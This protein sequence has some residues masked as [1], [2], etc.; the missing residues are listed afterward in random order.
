LD[1]VKRLS[2]DPKVPLLLGPW[3]S[4][5]TLMIA[6]LVND[7]G[8]PVITPV[9]SDPRVLPSGENVFCVADTDINKSRVLAE[10]LFED[11]HRK[12]AV[13]SDRGRYVSRTVAG[14]FSERFEELGGEVILQEDYSGGDFDFTDH[15]QEARERGAD[16]L[17]FSE[18]RMEP[19]VSLCRTLKSMDWDV[20]LATQVA[21]FGGELLRRGEGAVEGLYLSTTYVPEYANPEQRSFQESFRSMFDG[22]EATHREAQVYDSLRLAVEALDAVGPDREKLREYL[23]SI[24]RDSEPYHGV[25]GDFS[26][27]R[28]LNARP[29]YVVR[30]V[31][32][33]YQIVTPK[34]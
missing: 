29:A 32:G 9:S 14:L 12:A 31:K 27:S 34:S 23:T 15:A 1:I 5:Q 3:T 30:V 20:P 17:F 10:H 19:V 28:H 21:S 25:S 4:Q 8:L 11:G 33:A 13:F 6:P 24:G 16:C 22:R 18:Y 2:S 7:G 26:P